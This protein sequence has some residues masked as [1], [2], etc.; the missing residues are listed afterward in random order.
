MNNK[1]LPNREERDLI[2]ATLQGG[3]KF[4]G[5]IEI[6]NDDH[7]GHFTIHQ[8]W[9]WGDKLQERTIQAKLVITGVTKTE[10]DLNE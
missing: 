7:D 4:G 10:R 1:E 8:R 6:D 5:T 2:L 9:L 3:V